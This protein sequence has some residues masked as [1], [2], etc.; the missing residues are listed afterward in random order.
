MT[1]RAKA[2]SWASSR[3]ACELVDSAVVPVPRLGIGCPA[4]VA[5][6]VVCS[7]H[8]GGAPPPLRPLWQ[9]V[10]AVPQSCAFRALPHSGLPVLV[11]S[12]V[13]ALVLSRY[14]RRVEGRMQKSVMRRLA[15]VWVRDSSLEMHSTGTA[16][17]VPRRPTC[18]SL[19]WPSARR[20]APPCAGGRRGCRDA[21]GSRHDSAAAAAGSRRLRRRRGQ[22]H[23]C[24]DRGTDSSRGTLPPTGKGSR[25]DICARLESC[26]S[27][28]LCAWS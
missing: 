14:V 18:D 11:C 23:S 9:H 8:P 17:R 15:G 26:A 28:L 20:R 2:T 10:A 6:V 13:L 24:H 21:V 4:C 7:T 3:W 25:R 5:S 19:A 12:L 27:C 16:V 1:S 22:R